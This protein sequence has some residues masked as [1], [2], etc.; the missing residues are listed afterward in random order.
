MRQEPLALRFSYLEMEPGSWD[1]PSD[2]RASLSMAIQAA[3]Y[4]ARYYVASLRNDL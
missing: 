1:L 3:V 4:Q 2:L